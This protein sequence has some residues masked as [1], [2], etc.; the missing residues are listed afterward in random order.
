M[1][2]RNMVE[3]SACPLHPGGINDL[4]A[5]TVSVL[6][7][8][9]ISSFSQKTRKGII[10]DIIIRQ[11]TSSGGMLLT[12]VLADRSLAAANKISRISN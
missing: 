9:R 6:N 11:S 8:F 1:N 5:R 12:L 4:L 7:E 10:R 2:S 3:V